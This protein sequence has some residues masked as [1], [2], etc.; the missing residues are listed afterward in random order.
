MD[1]VAETLKPPFYAAVMREAPHQPEHETTVSP[2]DELVSIAPRQPGFL[3][4]ETDLDDQ[5]RWIAIS[6]WRDL[7]SFESWR[8]IGNRRFMENADAP[9][10]GAPRFIVNK[11]E[12]SL[13][14]SEKP[15][16]PLIAAAPAAQI[17]HQ[18][19]SPGQMI[20]GLFPAVAEFLGYEH[21]R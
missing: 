4:L 16:D 14:Q 9:L 12:H 13:A 1:T 17:S 11:I 2:A 8:A 19:R 6:Y 18:D 5:G 3:G 15:R 10:D 7:D 20:F 21:A